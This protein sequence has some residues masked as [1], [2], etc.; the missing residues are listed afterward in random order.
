M[1]GPE[2]GMGVSFAASTLK[3]TDDI[4]KQSVVGELNGKRQAELRR[5][6]MKLKRKS[7]RAPKC[8]IAFVKNVAEMAS[9]AARGEVFGEAEVMIWS[10]KGQHETHEEEARG[11]KIHWS[12]Y[13][14]CC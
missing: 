4:T 7:P 13:E 5:A 9:D 6:N 3:R 11:P 8:I 1:D 14:Q 2:T 10:D 12:I